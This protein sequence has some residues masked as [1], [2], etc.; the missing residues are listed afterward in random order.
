MGGTETAVLTLVALATS[1]LSGIVG[2]AGGIVL[3]TVMLLFMEPMVAIPLHAVV[4][5]VSNA[6]RTYIQRSHVNWSLVA[7][8]AIPLL[9]M[10]FVGLAIL[11]ALDPSTTRSLIGAFVL[12]GTWAPGWLLLGARP[13]QMRQKRRFL[14]LGTVVGA[15]NLTVG[16]TGPL[17]APFFLGLGLTRQSLVG[18]KAACQTLGH[19]TK[20]VIFGWVG[21]AFGEYALPLTLLCI[22]VIVG[23]WLGS[24]LL[25]RVSEV[26]FVRFYKI[27][28]TGVA[29]RLLLWDGLGHLLA[30]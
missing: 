20:I 23:T 11:Q 18:S 29:L 25:E 27:V 1:V 7:P 9:P 15:L 5:L 17:I 26:Y 4:Q 22:A 19:L 12:L 6:S 16:A 8:Y 28:L 30:Q 3:L 14:L 2:M 24:Q 13:E 21:F 10:G